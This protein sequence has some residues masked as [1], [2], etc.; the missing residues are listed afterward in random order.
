MGNTPDASGSSVPPWP[1]LTL[2]S[3]ASRH[4]RFTAPTACVEPSPTGL[5]RMI[6]PFIQRRYGPEAG[7]SI[8]GRRFG[9]FRRGPV[10]PGRRPVGR[11]ERGQ[12]AAFAAH[13]DRGKTV[14]PPGAARFDTD[15]LGEID[16]AAIAGE[17]A[18]IPVAAAILNPDA[19]IAVGLPVADRAAAGTDNARFDA[20]R[21]GL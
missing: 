4:T 17:C 13:D 10:L 3:P 18:I 1:T 14:E 7:L 21:A 2:P 16:V 20:E 12:R 6:Q 9:L 11:D 15:R 8:F 5:S 19:A